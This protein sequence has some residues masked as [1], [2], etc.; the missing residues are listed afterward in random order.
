[1]QVQ[2]LNDAKTNTEGYIGKMKVTKSLDRAINYLDSRF[3][4]LKR[5]LKT[6]K[7]RG[8]RLYSC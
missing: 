4:N 3:P 1:L 7:Y 2:L 6:L 8:Q 5:D